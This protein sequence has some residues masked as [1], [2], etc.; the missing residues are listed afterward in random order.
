[1]QH[2]T[3]GPRRAHRCLP[4]RRKRP[5]SNGAAEKRAS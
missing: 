2:T 5:R 4:V 3:P 1:M